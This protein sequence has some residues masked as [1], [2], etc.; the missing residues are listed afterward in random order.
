[1][2]IVNE[3]LPWSDNDAANWKAFLNTLTGQR[4]LPKIAENVPELLGAGQLNDILIRTGE[5]RG[6]QFS[7]RELLQLTSPPKPET[8]KEPDAYPDPT[9]D[10]KWEDGQKIELPQPPQ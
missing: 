4:L 10:S 3:L 5:V 8:R 2:Q 9:D 1:M 6:W 7:I